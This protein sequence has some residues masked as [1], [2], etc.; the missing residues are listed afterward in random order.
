VGPNNALEAVAKRIILCPCR[1]SNPGRPARSLTKSRLR[2]VRHVA[3][4]ISN[5]FHLT[6]GWKTC[7]NKDI[8]RTKV[9]IRGYCIS[10]KE[11]VNRPG[12]K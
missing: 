1:E 3:R 2:C 8:W 5:I 4:T 6:F 10:G 7:W 11:N 12:V 9:K